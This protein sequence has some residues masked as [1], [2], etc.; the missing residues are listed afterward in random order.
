MVLELFAVNFTIARVQFG[1]ARLAPAPVRRGAPP[2]T[3]TNYYENSKPERFFNT[4]NSVIDAEANKYISGTR[5]RAP[6][7]RETPKR[8]T[9]GPRP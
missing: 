2:R 3:L 9:I 1:G 4:L 5:S 6:N 8:E 7:A